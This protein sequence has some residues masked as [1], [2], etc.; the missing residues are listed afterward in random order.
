MV[1]WHRCQPT[2]KGRNV[3][4]H[5]GASA[6]ESVSDVAG[7]TSDCAPD[8]VHQVRLDR[9]ARVHRD[10]DAEASWD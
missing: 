4:T 5:S 2:A 9:R 1:H 8:Q 7:R 3:A 6:G 10:R